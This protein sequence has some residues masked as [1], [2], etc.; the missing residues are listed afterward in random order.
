V[1]VHAGLQTALAVAALHRVRRQPHDR[2]LAHH[3]TIVSPPR[4]CPSAAGGGGR[5][6]E[7]SEHDPGWSPAAAART[8]TRNMVAE[9]NSRAQQVGPGLGLPPPP[10]VVRVP[11][12]LLPARPVKRSR[13]PVPLRL[14]R[15]DRRR[16]PLIPLG[17]SL[18]P[19]GS[20]PRP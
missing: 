7:Q 4:A 11:D 17:R 10:D 9:T 8:S 20:R 3:P 19:A 1:A 16:R 13:S 2:D 5:R 15:E 18:P 14:T 6:D 12:P